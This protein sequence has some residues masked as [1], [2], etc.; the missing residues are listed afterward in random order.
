VLKDNTTAQHVARLPG[1]R[2]NLVDEADT[3]D[4]TLGP[5]TVEEPKKD[6]R[7][8]CQGCESYRAERD[9]ARE[10]LR[11]FMQ[12]KEYHANPTPS[13]RDEDSCIHEWNAGPGDY[14]NWNGCW[15]EKWRRGV[16]DALLHEKNH[17]TATYEDKEKLVLC[18][19]TK[20]DVDEHLEDSD[21][22][23]EFVQLGKRR[24]GWE[25]ESSWRSGQKRQRMDSDTDTPSPTATTS[26][27]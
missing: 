5:S 12:Q 11:I 15:V 24:R 7:V 19:G 21:D 2:Y 22:I 27:S 3:E 6:M 20:M 10:Q 9:L 4:V 16:A 18:V 1:G 25:D 23:D 14:S 17:D 26:G 13:D 8:I